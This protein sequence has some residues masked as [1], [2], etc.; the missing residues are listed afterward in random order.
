MEKRKIT[1]QINVSNGDYG[2]MEDTVEAII[3]Q[4]VN[5][6]ENILLVLDHCYPYKNYLGL[7][8]DKSSFRER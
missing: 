3:K 4:H 1:L 6:V 2:Y 8:K 5:N 7:R